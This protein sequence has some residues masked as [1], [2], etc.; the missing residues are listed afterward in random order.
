M[1]RKSGKD[2]VVR[3]LC[4][5]ALPSCSYQQRWQNRGQCPRAMRRKRSIHSLFCPQT[6]QR[7]RLLLCVQLGKLC[8][9]RKASRLTAG[10]HCDRSGARSSGLQVTA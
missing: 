1:R 3:E 10:S 8:M 6:E 9:D 7:V 4:S 2:V 5:M